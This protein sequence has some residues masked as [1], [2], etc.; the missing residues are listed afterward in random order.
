VV[1]AL[2][3][4]GNETLAITTRDGRAVR[5]SVGDLRG[6]GTQAI[7]LGNDDRVTGAVLA[8]PADELVVV[9]ADGYG[10]RLR[11]D[12]LFAPDKPNQKGKSLA[13]RKSEVVGTAVW[14]P[15]RPLQAITTTRFLP[16]D[17]GKLPLED[18]TKTQQLIKL[19][20]GE[21][22]NGLFVE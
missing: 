22:V 8:R 4:Q 2:G 16:L 20:K 5:W 21:E 7:N 1:A 10:R 19:E 15:E 6:S 17:A 3:A 11:V 18:S 12:W 9:L 13:A 14:S